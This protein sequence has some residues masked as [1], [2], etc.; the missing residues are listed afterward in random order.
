MQGRDATATLCTPGGCPVTISVS[1]IDVA[2]D[3][4]QDPRLFED[5]YDV[6]SATGF[7]VWEASSLFVSLLKQRS[8][9]LQ[10]AGRS[11]LELGSGTGFLA[12]AAASVGAH[13]LATDTRTVTAESIRP[14]IE[15]NCSAAGSTIHAIGGFA[16]EGRRA[17]GA[18]SVAAAALDWHVDA[19]HQLSAAG[20]SPEYDFDIILAA[21]CIWL[22]DVAAPFVNTLCSLMPA[23]CT[24][25]ALLCFQNRA[26]DKSTAFV[27]LEQVRS[28]TAHLRAAACRR[29]FSVI[30]GNRHN[31]PQLL[32]GPANAL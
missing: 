13:V 32:I 10:F 31:P 15:R 16:V 2:N 17:V 14:N 12:M 29:K 5:D 20:I 24:S 27:K 6:A 1:Q 11:V 8:V 23:D 28:S 25:V 4:T 9:Q 3:E 19:R 26:H 21:D 22:L 30:R 18:G 7:R